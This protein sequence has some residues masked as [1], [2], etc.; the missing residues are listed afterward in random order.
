MVKR[1]N[2]IF[3]RKK[4]LKINGIKCK[5]I[6]IKNIIVRIKNFIKV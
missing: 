2:N 3:K 5:T 4:E 1:Y 6:W